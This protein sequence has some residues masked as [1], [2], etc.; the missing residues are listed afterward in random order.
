MTLSA[1]EN[2]ML[3]VSLKSAAALAFGGALFGQQAAEPS[4]SPQLAAPPAPTIAAPQEAVTDNPAAS[5][6]AIDHRRQTF[7]SQSGQS[8]RAALGVTLTDD[9]TVSQVTP[10]S[11]AQQMGLRPGDQLLAL[12]GKTF[13]SADAFIDAVGSTPQGQSIRLEVDRDGQMLTPSGQLMAWDRIHYS[14]GPQSHSAMRFPQNGAPMQDAYG[15]QFADGQFA[16]PCACACD[17]CAGAVSY[18]ANFGFGWD[19]GW[20]NGWG[21]RAARRGWFY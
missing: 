15:G 14:S 21:R 13:D 11:P 17:P 9:L 12:D 2:A 18:G 19:D 10:G 6:P 1:K 4:R 16:D 3:F 5:S 8:G 20:N 7:Q